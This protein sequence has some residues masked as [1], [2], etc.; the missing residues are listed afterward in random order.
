MPPRPT[1]NASHSAIPAAIRSIWTARHLLFNLVRRDLTVR[2][3]STALGFLWSFAK[4]LA[5]MLIYHVVFTRIIPVR[6][7]EP[8]LPYGLHILAGLL[9]WAFF[10]GATSEAMNSI[11]ANANLVKK[12]KLP[13]EVF[14]VASVISQ[15]VNFA[16]AMVVLVVGM[17]AFGLAPGLPFLLLPAV[18]LLQ[19]VL[20]LALA[21]LLSSLNVFYRDVASVWEVVAAGWFYATPVVYPIGKA[22]DYL[23][24]SGRPA[25]AWLYLA[26]PMAPITVGYRRLTLY[27]ALDAPLKEMPDGE[28]LAAL[29]VA[30]IASLALLGIAHRIFT[31]LSRR[32]ADQL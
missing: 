23:R 8:R 21:L 26:N 32:F 10:V 18:A 29:G 5:Y 24:G 14:P 20:V 7:Q 22:L 28:L 19:C 25:L 1:P 15:A 2:Y 17:V 11:L 13:L 27:A 6:L 16:L 12:V 4:P 30:L 31:R 9:P 3:K